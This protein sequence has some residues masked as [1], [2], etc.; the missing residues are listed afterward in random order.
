MLLLEAENSKNNIVLQRLPILNYSQII[1]QY[2]TTSTNNL[3]DINY[4]LNLS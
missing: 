4:I 3:N 2:R 1:S